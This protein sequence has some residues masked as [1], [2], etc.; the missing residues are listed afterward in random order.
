MPVS[1]FDDMDLAQLRASGISIEE[2]QHQL[3]LFQKPTHHVDLVRPCTVGDGITALPVEELPDLAHR[4]EE[5]AR[6]GRFAKFVPASGAATRMFKDLFRFYPLDPERR[7]TIRTVETVAEEGD[8]PARSLRAFLSGID[9]FAFRENLARVLDGRGMDLVAL[10]TSGTYHEI[11][12]ALLS[13][14]G[15]GYADLPKGLIQFHRYDDGARTAF[16]EHLVEAASYVRDADGVCRLHFT[17]SPE[18]E[19][20]FAA[21]LRDVGAHHAGRLDCS[22]EVTY[23]V[24]KRSTDTLA[25]DVDNRPFRTDRG[26]LLFRPGGHGSLIENL[27]DLRADLVVIKNIDN[28]QP[29]HL[30]PLVTEWKRALGGHLLALEDRA[31]E[32]V[33]SL[34]E[35]SVSSVIV[36]EAMAFCSGKLSVSPPDR[37]ILRDDRKAR[38]WL[39]DRLDRPLRVCGVVRNT[40]EP[41]GGPFWVRDP[42]GRES[43]QIVETAQVDL[44]SEDQQRILSSSTHFNPVDLVCGLRDADGAPYDLLRFVDQ[45]A[46]IVT[47]KTAGGRELKALERPGLW[48]GGMGRWNTVFVE[49]PLETF[50]PVKTVN[51]LL[52]PEHQ[53]G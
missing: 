24:Q 35:G 53:P 8:E 25:V 18:H 6:R 12:E 20:A 3:F 10:S 33:R 23:S 43:L 21:L 22:F 36:A 2:V 7:P 5:A 9:R 42:R 1:S 4:H 47:R 13:S 37:S 39:L 51:D 11:L 31:H 52:R 48:N 26:R 44:E 29:D 38:A 41:G 34:R 14:E 40:G 50:S 19:E 16:E 32:F 27:D 30:K 17:V 28:V 15:L 46:V 45:D 49:V